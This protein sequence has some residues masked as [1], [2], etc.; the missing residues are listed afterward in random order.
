MCIDEIIKQKKKQPNK[1]K[2][3]AKDCVQVRLN[4]LWVSGYLVKVT[5]KNVSFVCDKN[6]LKKDLD[7]WRVKNESVRRARPY[8]GEVVENMQNW[9][10]WVS[11]T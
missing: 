8:I 10:H 1:H 3:K 11:M 6:I 9:R 5:W 2:F 4:D 7:I